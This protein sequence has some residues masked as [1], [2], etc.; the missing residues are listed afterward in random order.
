[1]SILSVLGGSYCHGEEVVRKVAETLGCQILDDLEIARRASERFGVP[2]KKLQR[3]LSGRVSAFNT[4]TNE[5]QHNTSYLKA[6]VADLLTESNCL[7]WGCSGH[8]IPGEISH[9]LGVCIVAGFD[10]RCEQLMQERAVSKKEALRIVQ[11]DDEAPMLWTNHVLGKSPWDSDIY[12]V[13]IPIDQ[14]GVTKS[15]ELI[16]DSANSKALESTQDSFQA[17]EDFQLAARVEIL[18]GKAGHDV[19]VSV[20]AGKAIL[21]IDKHTIFLS[22]LEEELK[23]IAAGIEGVREVETKVGPGFYQPGV[24]RRF[25]PELPSKVLLVDDEREYVQTLSERLQARDM[26]SMIVYN[27]EQAL[28]FLE[29]DEPEVMVLDL[30]M[31]GVDGI[32]VLRQIKQKHQSV[33]V[34]VLTG[35]GSEKDEELCMK[36]GAFAYLRKPVDIDRL[37]QTMQEA[38]RQVKA[39][40]EGPDLGPAKEGE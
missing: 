8:L 14:I 31:P 13:F 19:A 24:Y 20:K 30:R 29:D 36:L 6:V 33:E 35:H 40:T 21:T 15:I 3:T 4:F 38:Y 17:A 16:C 28:S 9:V 25:N 11:K 18:L 12:D 27:G 22:R 7:V 32:E 5:R 10:Y 26:G 37:S 34:I 23:K 2:Q 1:M 39:K